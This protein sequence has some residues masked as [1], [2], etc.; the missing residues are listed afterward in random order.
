MLSPY[1]L[2]ILRQ[3]IEIIQRIVGTAPQTRLDSGGTL[4]A[5]GN[6]NENGSWGFIDGPS[7]DLDE[8]LKATPEAINENHSAFY[9]VQLTADN[10]KKLYRWNTEEE[11]WKKLKQKP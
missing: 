11:C 8:M 4:F 9:I 10:H 1:E 5:V 3:A 2:D 7:F 6:T